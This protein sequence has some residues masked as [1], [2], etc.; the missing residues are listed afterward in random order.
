MHND[1]LMRMEIYSRFLP[2][3]PSPSHCLCLSLRRPQCPLKAVACDS[4][5]PADRLCQ[6]HR[7]ESV[8]EGSKTFSLSLSVGLSFSFGENSIS[9]YQYVNVAS[10]DGV[11]AER[12][13][14]PGAAVMY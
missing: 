1:S 10:R 12:F 7:Y 9:R 3:P 5:M 14:R 13:G 2:L 8:I 11:S 6:S 4:F